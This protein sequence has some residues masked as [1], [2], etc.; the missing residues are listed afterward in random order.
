MELY[1]NLFIFFILQKEIPY[2]YISVTMF[3]YFRGQN[4]TQSSLYKQ[5]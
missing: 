3:S 2:F 4:Q 5:S 1:R